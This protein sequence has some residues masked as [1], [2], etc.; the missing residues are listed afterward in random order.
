MLVSLMH[1]GPH[2]YETESEEE[3][4]I[5]GKRLK[6][7]LDLEQTAQRGGLLAKPHKE[8]DLQCDVTDRS[9]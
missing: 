7:L 8:K 5:L 2:S 6:E 1:H 4:K 9:N 3:G